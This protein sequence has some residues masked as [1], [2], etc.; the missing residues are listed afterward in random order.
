MFTGIV[1]SQAE[2]IS[3]SGDDSF[4]KITI[5][6]DLALIDNLTLGASI[7]INGTCLTVVSFEQDN[8]HGQ[9]T[10]DVIDE[11]LKLTNLG[12]LEL[13]DKVN[14]ERSLRMGDE[15]GGHLVSGHI[16]TCGT[17]VNRNVS[18]LNCELLI[19]VGSESLKYIFAKGFITVNGVS[20]TVGRVEDSCFSLHLIPET[21]ER[22]NLGQA[23]VGD[24]VNLEYDQQTMTIVSTIERMGLSV[25]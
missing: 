17:V 25:S 18:A 1:Q 2:I 11:T 3:V 13:G 19:E 15:L 6:G 20:L 21:L 24:S 12:A 16:H 22:T 9:V 14:V 4:K 8:K 10:F 5:Q 7:A 23:K